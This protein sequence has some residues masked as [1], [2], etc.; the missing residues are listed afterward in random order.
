VVVDYVQ[1]MD[2]GKKAGF[3][4]RFEEVSDI[5]KALKR[6]ANE[7]QVPV[8]VAAQ[9]NREL[10]A[11]GKRRAPELSDLAESGQL[12]RDA[13]Q[14][15]MIEKDPPAERGAAKSRSIAY[16]A[17]DL[18]IRKNRNGRTDRVRLRLNGAM[19]CFM[20]WSD[21]DKPHAENP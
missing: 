15:V 21:S 12:E 18:W 11:G 7:L 4:K 8:I 20:E 13:H 14:V 6:M 9:L 2:A 1:L 10:M 19:S 16:G 17:A 5:S 3:R